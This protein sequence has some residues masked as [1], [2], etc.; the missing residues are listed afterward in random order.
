VNLKTICQRLSGLT[1]LT[2]FRWFGT[3]HPLTIIFPDGN[4]W[5]EGI[6]SFV[7]SWFFA[8]VWLPCHIDRLI[9]RRRQLRRST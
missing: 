6:A 2:L 8:C 1:M 5:L 9:G 4:G 7:A 3:F